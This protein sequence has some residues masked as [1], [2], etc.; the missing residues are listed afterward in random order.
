M[1][2]AFSTWQ[3]LNQHKFSDPEAKRRA[4]IEAEVH[5]RFVISLYYEQIEN[6]R[7]FIHEHPQWATSWQL[8]EMAGLMEVPGVIRVRG[9]QCQYGAEIVRGKNRGAPVMKPTGFL[10]NSQAVAEALS[11]TC[12]SIDGTCSRRKGGRHQLCSGRH[13]KDAAVYP[14][15]LCRAILKGITAQ[16]KVDNLLLDGCYGVRTGGQRRR[17]D[18]QG[19]VRAGARLQR[20]VQRRPYW[21]SAEG[22]LGQAGAGEGASLLQPEGRVEKGSASHSAQLHW[23]STHIRPM[24]GRERG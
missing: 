18:P 19:D 7:Y 16:L 15:G 9:D 23:P 2:T 4:K 12:G 17:G 13:A 21:T 5:M 6:G 14:R 8:E 24:G 10:T 3:A 1:C 22:R 20:Q 11:K